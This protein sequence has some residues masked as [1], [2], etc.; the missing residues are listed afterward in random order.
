MNNTYE[1]YNDS[2][3]VML[4]KENHEDAKEILLN[5]YH[6]IIGLILKKYNKTAALLG[7]EGK[8]LYQEALLGFTDALNRYDEEKDASLPTF[9]TL[10]VERR[11]R[12]ILRMH[13]NSK[14]K[15]LS[16]AISLDA[17]T[18]NLKQIEDTK[19]KD[20]LVSIT[21]KEEASELDKQILG[22]L[23][24]QEKEVYNLLVKGFNIKEITNIL[25]KNYKQI[26]NTIQRI[27][28]KIKNI[29]DK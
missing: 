25:N 10:C 29:L 19:D 3:L 14:S 7:I 1:E 4:I 8:D 9:I 2:E 5:K 18:N 20:P 11:V 22:T 24:D 13:N 6:Y 17:E 28:E 12:I 16:D 26:D 21:D 27:K 15:L 23:S